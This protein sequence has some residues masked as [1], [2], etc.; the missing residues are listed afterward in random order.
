MADQAQ[1]VIIVYDFLFLI[2][3]LR[4]WLSSF[5]RSRDQYEV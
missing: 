2:F 5:D 3:L 4:K 1:T